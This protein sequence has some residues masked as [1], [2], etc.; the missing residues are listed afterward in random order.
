MACEIPQ[1]FGP[2]Q[3]VM[4]AELTPLGDGAPFPVGSRTT[5]GG[6]RW[7]EGAP[8]PGRATAVDFVTPS[9]GWA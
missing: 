7:T 2:S 1:F 4:A 3:A 9:V 6:A 8:L 5:D